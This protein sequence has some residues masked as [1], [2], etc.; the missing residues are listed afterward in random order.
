MSSRVVHHGLWN[1]LRIQI[2]Q[3]KHQLAKLE[4]NHPKF[5]SKVKQFRLLNKSKSQIKEIQTQ[6]EASDPH[7]PKWELS[8]SS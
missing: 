3:A 6:W 2:D 5:Y 1:Q 7:N 8:H 4:L